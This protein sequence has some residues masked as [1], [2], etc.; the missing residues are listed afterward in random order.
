[1]SDQRS[2]YSS[3]P[4]QNFKRAPKQR[5]NAPQPPRKVGDFQDEAMQQRSFAIL[6]VLLTIVLPILFIVALLSR[7]NTMYILFT[8]LSTG[9]LAAMWLLNAFVPNA[10]TTLSILH[11]AM[12]L[13]TLFAL[14]MSSPTQEPPQPQTPPVNSGTQQQEGDLQSIFN[15]DSSASLVNMTVQEEEPQA[16]PS[17]GS[18]S[19][20]QQQLDQFM[21]AWINVNYQRMV[22]LSLPSWVSQQKDP[23]QAMFQIRA[24]RSPLDYQFDGVSGSDADATRTIAMTVSISKNN[25][26]APMQYAMQVLMMRV[27][28]VW[29]VDPQSLGSGQPIAGANAATAVPQVTIAPLITASP[30]LPL[31]YNPEG[32]VLYHA[33]ANCTR[34]KPEYLP[35]KGN[36]LFSQLN[37][38]PFDKM[39]PC[40]TCHAPRRT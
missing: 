8:V 37:D 15:Q 21:A 35:M 34:L 18:A 2:R 13:V 30:S 22:D 24:N 7:S 29:Y 19:A 32:G 11:I 40:T 16:A 10:R 26:E 17:T 33:D 23:Q 36:F 20:A 38:P 14:W 9:S 12:I 3:A 27:N 28:D 25:G 39:E 5:S 4:L 6:Q 1:M 31:Y